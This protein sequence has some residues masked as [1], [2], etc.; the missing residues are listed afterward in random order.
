ML[1]PFGYHFVATDT[2]GVNLF[3]VHSSAAGHQPLLTLEDAKRLFAGGEEW[4]MLNVLPCNR[5]VWVAIGDDVDY[6]AP[7]FKSAN[8]PLVMLA[9]KPA[10]R[11]NKQRVFYAV[12][13][14]DVMFKQSQV[15]WTNAQRVPSTLQQVV[16]HGPTRCTAM[17]GTV[18]MEGWVM[19]TML[20]AA[21]MVGSTCR[22]LG[23]ALLRGL[24]RKRG[25][26]A[27]LHQW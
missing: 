25:L 12:K 2:G 22:Q 6:V 21:F 7:D 26:H 24:G 11:E 27:V 14:V 5:M 8:L 18:F 23:S 13:H 10:G 3:F 19:V 4:A 1:K 9:H 20:A 16:Q 15:G 17:R